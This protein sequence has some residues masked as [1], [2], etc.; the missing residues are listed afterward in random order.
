ML[1]TPCPANQNFRP[2][3]AAA[4]SGQA[5]TPQESVESSSQPMDRRSF[6]KWGAVAAASAAV[7]AAL[8]RLEQS[9]SNAP[10]PT[11]WENVE[12][13]PVVV[14]GGGISGIYSGWRLRG[15]D[16]S[17]PPAGSSEHPQV[18]IFEKS[19]HIGGRI[20]SFKVQGTDSYAELGAMRYVPARHYLVRTLVEDKLKLPTQEFATSGPNL[21][22]YVRGKHLTLDQIARDPRVLPY[23]LPAHEQGKSPD[24]LIEAAINKVIPNAG[25]LSPADWKQIR[26]H[27]AVSVRNMQS[28][29]V[30]N[31]EL[32]RV[33]FQNLIYRGMSPEA[34]KMVTDM[35]GYDSVMQNAESITSI[36]EFVSD[37][38]ADTTYRTLTN[39]M[40]DLPN[41]MQSQFLERGGKIFTRHDMQNIHYDKEHKCFVL[42]FEADGETKTVLADKVVL[43]MPQRPL[44][45]L[46]EKSPLLNR[47]EVRG[48]L[49][50][51]KGNPMTRI[52]ARY[53]NAWWRDQGITQGKSVTDLPLRMV[54][55]YGGEQGKDGYVMIYNDGAHDEFWAG[56]QDAG[57]PNASKRFKATPALVEE[58]QSELGQMHDRTDIPAPAEV[59]YR[60]WAP[61]GIYGGAFHTWKPGTRPWETTEKMIQPLAHLRDAPDKDIPL[62]VCGEAYSQSQGWIQGALET[63][64]DVLKRMGKAPLGNDPAPMV[65]APR[66][67][68]S[69]RCTSCHSKPN[70]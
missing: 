24:A 56:Y 49:D 40:M 57:D 7:P 10:T 42:T 3:A 44:Q 8:S 28:G 65:F 58:L 34:Y 61:E 36:Q 6:L 46:A 59:I 15:C 43:A 14:V 69:L 27:G 1:I 70:F 51:V 38:S 66:A 48:M 11:A 53:K 22:A 19:I 2:R 63:A 29:A 33:G 35:V 12:R 64:E 30:S 54:Y 5:L 55:Y 17:A 20:K 47:P 37:F 32:N 50:Q 23:N 62:Y 21:L 25:K 68:V 9:S 18:A 39:G 45:L 13:Y 41:Q 4:G 67:P 26:E 16:G 52:I 31:L 60:R